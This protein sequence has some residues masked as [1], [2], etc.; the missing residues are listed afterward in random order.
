MKEYTITLNFLVEAED[1]DFEKINEFAE[2][3]SESIMGDDKLVFNNDIEIIDVTIVEVAG[4]N[5][6]DNYDDDDE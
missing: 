4:E 6:E 1:A 2:Q 3:L 5:Y